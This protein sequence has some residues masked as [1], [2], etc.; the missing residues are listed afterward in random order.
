MGVSNEQHCEPLQLTQ[1]AVDHCKTPIAWIQS[2]AKIRY[3]NLAE[4]EQLGY[5]RSELQTMT[6]F[7]VDPDCTPE[8][9]PELWSVLKGAG[10][11]TF[12][13]RHQRSDGSLFP[14][15]VTTNYIAYEDSEYLFAFVT[16]LSD[17]KQAEQALEASE[18]KLQAIFDHHYQLTGLLGTDGTLL[19]ANKTALQFAGIGAHEAIG[20]NFAESNWWPEQEKLTIQ[21]AI[22]R[23]AA[24]EFVRFETIHIRHDGEVR[25]FDF[26]LTPVKNGEGQVIFLVPEG[27]DVTERKQAEHKLREHDRMIRDLVESTRDWIWAIDLNGVLTYCNPAIE[28]ILGIKAEE[29]IGQSLTDRINEQDLR[30][31]QLSLNDHITTQNGWHGWVIRWNHVN[32]N[33]RYLESN[34]VP[35]FD[36]DKG[37]IGF[38]GVDRDITDQIESA[39]KLNQME[40]QLAHVARLSAMGELTAG[41]THELVQPLH[42][43]ANLARAITNALANPNSTSQS[44]LADWSESIVAASDRAVEIVQRMKSF[45]KRGEIDHQR[46]SLNSLLNESI[47]LVS[48]EARRCDVRVNFKPHDHDLVVD[49]D[50]IQIQQVIVNLLRNAFDS[51][52]ASP[53]AQRNLEIS[54]DE[55]DNLA[56]VSF[57]D[58]GVG[59]DGQSNLDIFEPFMTTKESGMGLGLALSK[60]IAEAHGGRLWAEASEPAGAI[61]YFALPIVDRALK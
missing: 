4:C 11:H 37:L 31:Y 51:M 35:I 61:F 53:T 41:I 6:V 34:S 18:T 32:G 56:Q 28:P 47:Q 30:R 57:A 16:D 48:F 25:D 52:A 59:L 22:R 5:S 44:D 33:V 2:D 54:I 13:A 55:I 8:K 12:E 50:R 3:V 9:W 14:V 19:A 21:Q 46:E 20:L 15:E 27:R 17:Q 39:E 58:N 24:G 26:S 40:N 1:F 38:R 49:V 29:L 36:E 60:S 43:I 7:D 10:I 42:A 45:A 23:A